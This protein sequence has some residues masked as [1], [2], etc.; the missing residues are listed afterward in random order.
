MPFVPNF[1]CFEV[2]P[3]I[4]GIR[5]PREHFVLCARTSPVSA[6]SQDFAGAVLYKDFSVSPAPRMS[7]FSPNAL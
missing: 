3:A 2:H 1:S 4:A 6:F 7:R 5:V